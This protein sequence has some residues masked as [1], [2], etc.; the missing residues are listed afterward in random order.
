MKPGL[1]LALGALASAP[2]H[3]QPSYTPPKASMGVIAGVNLTGEVAS[4]SLQQRFASFDRAARKCRQDHRKSCQEQNNNTTLLRLKNG[5]I[6]FDAK[7]AVDADGSDYAKSLS[8]SQRGTNSPNTSLRY[9]LKGSPSV[10]A[11]HVAYIAIPGGGFPSTLNV[12]VGDVA[13]VVH[14]DK[15]AYAVV[16]DIGPENQIGEGS[17]RLHEELGHS[18]CKT[19][20]EQGDCT[21]IVEQSIGS[22]VMFFIFPG[23]HSG[24]IA[25]LTPE[26]I[27]ARIEKL[28]SLRWDALKTQHGSSTLTTDMSSSDTSR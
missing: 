16:A 11:D 19:R 13:V 6:F 3:T 10:D 12:K 2:L 23:T 1:I 24:F 21:K 27:N 18:V 28:A 5:T 8:S 22:D 25:G 26:N 15:L 9:P 4:S 14:G 17:L 7:L 20:N